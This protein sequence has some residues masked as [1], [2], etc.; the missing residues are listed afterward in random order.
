VTDPIIVAR[1]LH[2]AYLSGTPMA[3]VSLRDIDL[4]VNRDEIVALVGPTGSGK[5]TLLQ[6]LNGLLRPQEG[7]VWVDGH[8]LGDPRTDLRLIRRTVGLVFQRPEDQIFEQYVGDDVAYGPRIG[9]MSKPALRERVRWAME[10]VGLDFEQYKDRLTNTLSGGER[11]KV[12][13][14]G[15]LALRP[16]VLL[17]DEPTA[18]LDPAARADLLERL[19]ALHSEGVT[20]VLSTHNMDDVASLADRVYVLQDGQMALNGATRQVFSRIAQL[21]AFGLDVPAAVSIMAALRKRGLSVPLD[22]L[23]LAEAENAIV[24]ALSGRPGMARD[25]NPEPEETS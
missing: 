8:E 9:G 11:R 7:K 18:G 21:R 13:L 25:K 1:G 10:L 16:S 24:E 2:H 17:L 14:A 23:S 3:Q 12:G 20:L 5:S 22:V 19:S 4:H 6:H 15:V